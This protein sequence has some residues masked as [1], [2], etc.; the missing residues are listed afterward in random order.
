MGL[1]GGR[2]RREGTQKDISASVFLACLRASKSHACMSVLVGRAASASGEILVAHNEDN[3]GRCEMQTHLVRK[4]RR[5]PNTKFRFEPTLADLELPT[6]RTSLFWAEAKSFSPDITGLSFCDS[7]LNG[8]GLVIVSNNCEHSREDNP[9]LTEGGIGYGLRRIV[10]EAAHNAKEAVDIATHLIDKYGYASSGRSYAFAD[11]DEIF[12]LQ[13]VHGKHY[14][15]QRV[16]DDEVAVIPNHYTIHEPD[17]KAHGYN[18]LVE[19]AIKRGWYNPSDGPFD[20]KRVY[21][22]DDSY[23]DEHNTHRHV[24]AFQLLLDID[25]SGLLE[26]TW[27]PL[28]F[29]IKPAHPVN[30]DMLKRILRTHFEGTSSYNAGEGSPHFAKPFPVCNSQT[31]ESSIFQIRHNPDRIIIR[32]ALGSPC[33]SPYIAWYFGII[34]DPEGYEDKDPDT[35]L[36]EHFAIKPEDMDYRNNAWYRAMEI[37]TA[38]NLLYAEKGQYVHQKVKE[39]EDEEERKFIP[40]DA[41]LELRI[42]NRPDIAR[43]MMEGAVMSFASEAEKFAQ[44]M[45]KELGIIAGEALT[46]A[47]KGHDFSVRIPAGKISDDLNI[48]ACICGPSYVDVM[49]WSHCSTA[50]EE[51]G[52]IDLTFSG[53]EWRDDAVPCF[54][55]LYMLIVE[56][57]GKKHVVTVKVRVRD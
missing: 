31:L 41:Q 29:S 4:L 16:P 47:V 56:K 36:A 32:K 14:A 39:V 48:S 46:D 45:H 1:E 3:P 49:N 43:A 11:K 6:Q 51:E 57:S 19:Y 21:Q 25:L 20:F 10:A 5:H 55:D 15:I 52:Y 53:G 35:S 42:R 33:F 2:P 24:R 18:E 34:A 50:T 54:T 23:A 44:N 38:C 17:K 13:V 8:H 26:K 40:L 30:I 28:P 37:Q 9:D 22:A 7:Y 27:E 12:V